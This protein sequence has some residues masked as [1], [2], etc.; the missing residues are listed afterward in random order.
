MGSDTFQRIGGVAGG[1]APDTQGRVLRNVVKAINTTL[2][3]EFL[4]FPS[5]AMLQRNAEE[6]FRKYKLPNFGWAVDGV[7]MPFEEKPRNIPAEIPAKD[8]HNRKLR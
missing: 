8:F 1:F 4:H 6:N 5:E 7:H 2:K 3:D